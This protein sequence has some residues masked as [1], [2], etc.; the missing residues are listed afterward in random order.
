MSDTSE[1]V[2]NLASAEAL[3]GAVLRAWRGYRGLGLDAVARHAEI[4]VTTLSDWEQGK[5]RTRQRREYVP[6]DKVLRVDDRLRGDGALVGM[7][8]AVGSPNALPARSDWMCNYR[9]GGRPG[10]LWIRSRW[11]CTVDVTWG[12]LRGRATVPAGPTGLLI[13]MPVTVDNPPLRVATTTPVWADFGPAVIPREVAAG[14]GAT[15]VLGQHL[16]QPARRTPRRVS[17][18]TKLNETVA[19]VQKWAESDLR[20]RWDLVRPHIGTVLT[21]D[22]AE[23]ALDGA[24]VQTTGSGGQVLFDGAGRLT[25]QLTLGQE[26]IRALRMARGY[27]H[28]TAAQALNAIAS[29]L[30]PVSGA[31]LERL[32]RLGTLPR[33]EQCLSRL[34]VV[35][36]AD[37]RL[38]LERTFDSTGGAPRMKR[39][40]TRWLTELTFPRYWVGPVWVQV[41]SDGGRSETASLRLFWGPWRQGRHV[42]SGQVFSTRKARQD[43]VPLLVDLPPGWHVLAGTGAVSSARD[44]NDDWHPRSPAA[45]L[46]LLNETLETLSA[47]RELARALSADDPDLG[48]A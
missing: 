25:T 34:D 15:W 20:L 7:W 39:F 13:Q 17:V 35:Y 29:D 31:A 32:E 43:Q 12:P 37:G 38:G 36:R 4:S 48:K 8:Q 26:Q 24:D 2:P 22:D 6:L 30:P 27:S 47:H 11:A 1:L 10:W 44:I 9:I 46:A 23:H 42:V 40:G 33:A 45:A 5:P 14:L 21:S 18:A 19:E 28:E 3:R 16:Q 41:Q